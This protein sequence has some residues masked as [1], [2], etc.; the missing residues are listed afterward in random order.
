M[1]IQSVAQTEEYDA[2]NDSDVVITTV[3]R[4]GVDISGGIPDVQLKSETSLTTE[5]MGTED[6][7]LIVD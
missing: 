1:P 6:D 3:E 4:P 7:P 2:N 5:D